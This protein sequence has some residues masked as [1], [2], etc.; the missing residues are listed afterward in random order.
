MINN[1]LLF[2]GLTLGAPIEIAKPTS[3]WVLSAVPINSKVA[4]VA[5]RTF[6]M[7]D[8]DQ[9]AISYAC[10]PSQA[11]DGKFNPT[12]LFGV[13]PG[14]HPYKEV[15]MTLVETH[16]SDFNISFVHNNKITTL[17]NWIT[18]GSGGLFFFEKYS[19]GGFLT[20][21]E[22]KLI[23]TSSVVVIHLGED[24]YQA[25]LDD[26]PKNDVCL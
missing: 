25:S 26:L 21:S 8:G 4:T 15:P 9:V 1:I 23:L 20:Q 12:F 22:K 10:M 6:V 14:D 5:T 18:Y 17:D 19:N 11:Y 2:I 24:L 13:T 3:N 7:N 16:N